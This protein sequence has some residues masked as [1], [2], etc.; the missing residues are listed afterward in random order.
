MADHATY[1]LTDEV[2]FDELVKELDA[3]LDA[4]FMEAMAPALDASERSRP[5]AERDAA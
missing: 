4:W 2:P 5:T 1:D 3:L